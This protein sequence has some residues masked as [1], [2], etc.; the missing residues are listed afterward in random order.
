MNKAA[1]WVMK[2][3]KSVYVSVSQ[4]E[5]VHIINKPYSINI[6]NT[7]EYCQNIIIWNDN[8]L[9]V[10]DLS[11]LLN[12]THSSS[13]LNYIAVIIYRDANSEIQ[14][15]GMD[16]AESPEL[17]YVENNQLCELPEYSNEIQNIS[18]SCFISKDGH[19]VP[20]LDMSKLFSR[21]FSEEFVR[22]HC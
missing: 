10:I 9:P 1:A 20:I 16:L 5:L 6:P 7:P 17:E 8:I 14:Y 13:N 22:Q 19:E 12:D 15:G 18:L 21:N 2:V 4:L 3:N 11:R